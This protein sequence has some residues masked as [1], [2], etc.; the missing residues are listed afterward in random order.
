MNKLILS[1]KIKQSILT[2]FLKHQP[3]SQPQFQLQFSI[4]SISTQNALVS[5]LHNKINLKLKFSKTISEEEKKFF[6]FKSGFTLHNTDF[7]SKEGKFSLKKNYLDYNIHVIYYLKRFEISSKEHPIITLFISINKI[8]KQNG[9]ICKGT[10]DDVSNEVL[11][12]G[13]EASKSCWNMNIVIYN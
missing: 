10:L 4:K 9:I 6:Q 1:H 2:S 7:L 13:N 11:L 8:G 3:Q 5:E 12:E